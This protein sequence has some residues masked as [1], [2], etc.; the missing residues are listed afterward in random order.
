[1]KIYGCLRKFNTTFT[2]EAQAQAFL[3][4]QIDN[5]DLGD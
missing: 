4:D 2:T 5:A 1:M 3:D